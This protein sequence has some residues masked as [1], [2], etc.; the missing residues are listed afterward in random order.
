MTMKPFE[1][2][3]VE[4]LRKGGIGVIPTDTMYGIVCSAFNLESIERL[5]ELRKRSAS[6]KC[7]IL[8][9]DIQ[10]L[11]KFNISLDLLTQNV[12]EK[13]WPGSVSVEI[14]VPDE[15][16]EYLTKGTGCLSFRLPED[17][18]LREL[19]RAT[20]PLI[21]PSANPE[22]EAPAETIEEVKR[23]FD[24]LDFYV[25][26]GKL[27]GVPSTIISILNGKV[28]IWRQGKGKIP[29]ELIQDTF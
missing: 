20:G 4:I 9:G 14:P 22:G 6:K 19:L 5:Y 7:I 3:I 13:V 28:K 26:S 27:P 8:I 18:S 17:E 21:A 23:Y 1:A 15:A 2:N 25:D 16:F 24:A 10:D 11:E 12:L 29:S